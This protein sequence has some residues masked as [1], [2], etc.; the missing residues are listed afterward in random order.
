[1]VRRAVLQDGVLSRTCSITARHPV[2]QDAHQSGLQFRRRRGTGKTP[3]RNHDVADR[4]SRRR[5]RHKRDDG[6]SKQVMRHV[7]QHVESPCP[8]SF[9][10]TCPRHARCSGG[11]GWPT[12]V[13]VT[14]YVSAGSRETCLP[15]RSPCGHTGVCVRLLKRVP[16]QGPSG[17]TIEVSRALASALVYSRL[18]APMP[19]SRPQTTPLRVRR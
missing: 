14:T 16:L 17:E 7:P 13:P 9:R 4:A 15:V 5:I 12:I 6:C 8:V 11:F 1:M 19:D 10:S 18:T 2:A 3:Q